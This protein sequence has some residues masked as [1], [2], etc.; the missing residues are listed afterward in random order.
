[1][2]LMA[3][4]DVPEPLVD[5]GIDAE[6]DESDEIYIPY[7]PSYF[8]ETLATGTESHVMWLL[9]SCLMRNIVR[10]FD[11]VIFGGAVR[12]TILHSHAAGKFYFLCANTPGLKIKDYDNP[13]IHPELSDRFLIPKDI[14]FFM[15][16][17]KFNRFKK[18]LYKKGFYFNEYKNMDLS[19]VNKNLHSGEY[20]LM[21]AEIIYFDKLNK[22]SY[23]ILLD[24][25]LSNQQKIVIPQMDPD[26]NVNKLI[27]TEK[28]I[29]ST[30]TEWTFN[31]IKECIHKKEAICYSIT[32]HARYEKMKA[33]GWKVTMNYSTFVF[34]L[35]TNE[36]EETCVICLDILKVG[37]LE[38]LPKEC[39][40]KYSYCKSCLPYTLKST[41]CL[42]CKKDMCSH[43]KECDIKMYEK[44]NILN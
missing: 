10:Q 34:K 33:K 32:S 18:Y 35:R 1:M 3:I 5:L 11:G 17:L 28:G 13:D 21:K 6:I 8:G 43:K 44:Y 36:E 27:M 29:I 41:Q 39:K 31:Q 22:K 14:D 40:C 15:N 37:E 7:T 26:F 12:D 23:P 20:N 25:I 4:V 2:E 42:M 30:S 9:V 24:I 19:Y 16:Y 38:V